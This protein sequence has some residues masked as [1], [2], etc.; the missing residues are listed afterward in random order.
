MTTQFEAAV[1]AASTDEEQP[2]PID[3]DD[4]SRADG[5]VVYAYR[6][7]DGQLALLMASMGRGM[8]ANEAIAATVNFFCGLFE[9][10]DRLYIEERLL[11]RKRNIE[12]DR[13]Q[14]LLEGLIEKWSAR[15][16][17]SPSGSAT[18]QPTGGPNSTPTTPTSIF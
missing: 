14:E 18:S 11:S 4:I 10:D 17:Q 13:I 9:D 7:A 2:T 16:T 5:K 12:I 3:I 15:P 6:P 8:A 1:E